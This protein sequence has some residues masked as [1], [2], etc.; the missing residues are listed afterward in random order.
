M[1]ELSQLT[2]AEV[3]DMIFK[4][5]I[6]QR[7]RIWFGDDTDQLNSICAAIDSL[8]KVLGYLAVEEDLRQALR[9]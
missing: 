7:S 5:K 3:S 2:H 6:K 1:R 8:E 4:L 9:Q